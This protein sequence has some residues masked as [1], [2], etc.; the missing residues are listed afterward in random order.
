MHAALGWGHVG[1]QLGQQ[2]VMAF[3]NVGG[4]LPCGSQEESMAEASSCLQPAVWAVS[5]WVGVLIWGHMHCS[6]SHEW[7]HKEKR[8][9][10]HLI[11]AAA[12][13]VA[14][15]VVAWLGATATTGVT[16]YGCSSGCVRVPQGGGGGH[17]GRWGLWW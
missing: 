4:I 10:Q 13:A 8:P 16:P 12:A 6:Q 1:G 3:R 11:G 9:R 7:Q 15:V 14:A 5:E 2:H 17:G